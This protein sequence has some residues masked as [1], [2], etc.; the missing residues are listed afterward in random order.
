MKGGSGPDH[1]LGSV[2]WFS[3][4]KACVQ[5]LE[6]ALF[7][8][9]SAGQLFFLVLSPSASG[10]SAGPAGAGEPTLPRLICGGWLG[11]DWWNL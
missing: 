9:E 2:L 6:H 1:Q 8:A 3:G 4:E 10:Q 7:S 5:H 11:S